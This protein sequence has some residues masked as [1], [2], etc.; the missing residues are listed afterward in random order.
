MVP[1]PSLPVSASPP[2]LPELAL[3]LAAGLE[4]EDED[5]EASTE[6]DAEADAPVP[7]ELL[8]EAE[9]LS[10][11]AA[12]VE[13]LAD[14]L[15]ELGV[16]DGEADSEVPGVGEQTSLPPFQDLIRPLSPLNTPL[17]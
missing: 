13:S 9:A 5:E 12:V 7:V 17:G 8:A 4:D 15:A 2:P 10:D 1:V 16:A 6:E 14:G 3:A 11:G